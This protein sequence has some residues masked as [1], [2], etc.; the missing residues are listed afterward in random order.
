MTLFN[1]IHGPE[2]WI[3][4]TIWAS[5]AICGICA[6]WLAWGFDKGRKK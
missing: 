3:A 4:I 1:I 2:A 6:M 5:G